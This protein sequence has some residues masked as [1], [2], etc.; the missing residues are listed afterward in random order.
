MHFLSDVYVKCDQCQGKRYSNEILLIKYKYKN[1]SDILDMTIDE[2]VSFFENHINIR[3]KLKKL[4]DVGVGYLSI[5]HSSTLL[6]GGEAQR[7]KLA[8]ELC[9]KVTGKTLY[10][11]DEP[12]TGLHFEDIRKLIDS[13]NKLVSQGS[14]VIIIEHNLEVIKMADWII[15]LGPEG[16]DA[17]GFVVAQGPPED[18][19]RNN[20]SF[21]GQYLKRYLTSSAARKR[22]G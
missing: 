7:V 15:D 4:Q 16:G 22:A 6:S 17:G 9:R 5:G 18:I 8:K 21:T 1:I 12:T 20:S 2:G 19:V 14:S 13:L 11:F 3:E 10:I